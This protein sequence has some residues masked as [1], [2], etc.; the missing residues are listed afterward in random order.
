MS[1]IKIELYRL[2]DVQVLKASLFLD[3]KKY[4]FATVFFKCNGIILD[5][6]S[7]S[8][9]S[10][11]SDKSIKLYNTNADVFM[12]YCSENILECLIGYYDKKDLQYYETLT[13]NI[14]STKD[15]ESRNTLIQHIKTIPGT[16][17]TKM[18]DFIKALSRITSAWKV[19]LSCPDDIVLSI[20]TNSNNDA[21]FVF[22]ENS[23][24]P[25]SSDLS[26]KLY[27]KITKMNIPKEIVRNN[28]DKYSSKSELGVYEVIKPDFLG[29]NVYYKILIS[30]TLLLS[31]LLK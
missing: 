20:T 17:K 28:Y 14:D 11:N 13:V 3:F 7:T 24:Q 1:N 19:S 29:K 18:D 10:I 27:S 30:N 12:E 21:F 22:G 6:L 25:I 5:I 26:F 8:K 23:L 9:G 31:G 2:K 16:Y 15:I 4:E